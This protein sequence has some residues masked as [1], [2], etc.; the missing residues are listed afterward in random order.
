MLN[1][2]FAD[3]MFSQDISNWKPKKLKSKTNAFIGTKLEKDNL[4]PYWANVSVKI[5]GQAIEAY[6]LQAKLSESLM[7]KEKLQSSIKI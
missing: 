7:L 2:A 1:Y 6:E 5:L 3:S 4:V